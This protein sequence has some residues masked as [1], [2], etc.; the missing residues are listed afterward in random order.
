MELDGNTWNNT[1]V[2]K[3]FVLDRNTWY[4]IIV[5]KKI[6]NFIKDLNINV[7]AFLTSMPKIFQDEL[8]SR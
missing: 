7:R 5:W 1:T 8:T 6:K 3:L 2:C 4:H